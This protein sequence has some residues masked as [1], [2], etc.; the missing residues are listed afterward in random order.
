MVELLEVNKVCKDE[1]NNDGDMGLIFDSMIEYGKS[2][3]YYDI[4]LEI[5]FNL[6]YKFM[7]K[8]N[9]VDVKTDRNVVIFSSTD[10]N[11]IDEIKNRLIELLPYNIKDIVEYRKGEYGKNF[12]IF[13]DYVNVDNFG[14]GFDLNVTPERMKEGLENSD[15][16]YLSVAKLYKSP[17]LR[18]KGLDKP[19]KQT[20]LGIR[21]RQNK[22]EALKSFNVIENKKPKVDAERSHFNLFD[23]LGKKY[24]EV[25]D[26]VGDS[27]FDFYEKY[28]DKPQPETIISTESHQNPLDDDGLNIQGNTGYSKEEEDQKEDNIIST[29]S[30]PNN[31]NLEDSDNIMNDMD[32]DI[33]LFKDRRSDI[34]N[35]K[36]TS[37]DLLNRSKKRAEDIHDIYG[38]KEDDNDDFR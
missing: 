24:D 31:N 35:L 28:I 14:G 7:F 18:G 20:V 34:L 33:R 9:D 6:L 11:K 5:Y 15:V 19:Y 32:D 8:N 26:W 37:A 4:S 1:I 36:K 25:T 30:K 38:K 12:T 23:S 21:D 3:K 10:K 16:Y 2:L 17:P 29:S 22:E 27:I 13:N